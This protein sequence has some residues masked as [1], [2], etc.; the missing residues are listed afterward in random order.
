MAV[1]ALDRLQVTG[2]ARETVQFLIR[3]HLRMSLSAFRRD[4]EDPE[5]VKEFARLVGTEDRLKM[6]CLLTLADIEAV[7]PETL[8]PWKEELIWRLYVDT[9]NQLTQAY[10]D[11][12]IERNQAGPDRTARRPAAGS[13]RSGDHPLRRRAAAA[14]PAALPA[15]RHLPPRAPGARHP[16]G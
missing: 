15:R 13:A 9:Y 2:E 4:T 5:I 3:N 12:L 1:D 14:V 7:S 8:T 16:A 10:G 11:E 6:L